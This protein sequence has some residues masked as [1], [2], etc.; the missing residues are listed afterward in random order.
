MHFFKL[1]NEGLLIFNSKFL[2][3]PS[4]PSQN[5]KFHIQASKEVLTRIKN[6]KKH[7]LKLN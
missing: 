2:S 5:P 1:F 7:Y 6:S 4:I 3:L